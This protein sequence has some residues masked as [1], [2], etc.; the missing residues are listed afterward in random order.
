MK[1][2]RISNG[3][4]H[5]RGSLGGVWEVWRAYKLNN[6]Y[7]VPWSAV[8]LPHCFNGED[9]VDP[10]VLYYQGPGW[11]R[12]LLEVDNPYPNG[13]TLLHFEGAGQ[14]TEVYLYTEQVARHVG[15]YDEFKVDL[16]E[17][18]AEGKYKELF[19]NKV[20]VAVQC[21]NT[22]D[23]ETIPSDISDF[24][25]YGGIYRYLNLVYVPE[26]SFE[27]VHIATEVQSENNA[28]ITVRAKL[29]N[30]LKR[31]QSVRLSL[32]VR[33]PDGHA[34]HQQEWT[35]E[36]WQGWKDL[37]T[38]ELTDVKRWSPDHPELYSCEVVMHGATGE[39]AWETSHAERFGIRTFEFVKQGPFLLNGER[40]LLR[41]THRH[42]D[43]AG[44]AAAMTEDMI[45]SEMKLIKEMGA[46]FIR[47]GHYQQSRIV[48]ELC[49]ELGLLVWEEIP[50]CRG[51][52]GGEAYRQQC[53]DM[54]QAMIEQHYNHPSVIVWG[55]GNE[56]D[57]ESDFDTFDEEE[58]RRFMKELHDL[59]HELDDSRVT[60]IRRCEFCKDIIDVYSPSIWAGWY[61]GVYPEYEASSRAGFEGTDRFLHLEW[62]ADN[63]AGRHVEAPYTG[64]SEIKTGDGTDERDG[65]YFLQGGDPR[66]SSLG[67]W[68][69]TYFCDMIDWYLKSQTQ[70]D[71]LT[72]A[73]QWAFKDFSTPVRPDSPIPY[74]NMKGVVQRDLTPKEAY[75]VFQSYWSEKPMIRVYNH[76]EA[77]R[78]G[79]PGE[80]K[81][82]KVYSNCEQA[83][84]FLN[85]QSVGVRK[86]DA[87]DFPCAG[88][89]WEVE[90]AEGE[91][92]VRAVGIKN[93]AQVAD[94]IRFVYQTEEW[95]Q[96][97]SAVLSAN[98]L[99]DGLVK[100]EVRVYDRNGVY[101]PDANLF[102][103][104]GLAGDG[105]LL[106]NRGTVLGSRYL[107]LAG[108]RA[109]ILVDPQ[110]G[111]SVVS[112]AV[113]GIPTVFVEI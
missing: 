15:G 41:G 103:R 84:L 100:V 99:E 89:R 23:L 65:D 97:A 49:D 53:R 83:E 77:V 69:E 19:G 54:L 93:G 88:L 51:G 38:L 80:K 64:F 25:L 18:M 42:E 76:S 52:I 101:C 47:L 106:D 96:P 113:D 72:G 43:F 68:S 11:Y 90:L 92:E 5:Y 81:L 8:E 39:E 108:G 79:Q 59:S 3:W 10:D 12:T 36:A 45:R 31:S 104:F 1:T 6:H 55:L 56:N 2:K 37:A 34:V 74:L 87:Q 112:A 32:V 63:M 78:W 94:E 14:N 61:R 9:S 102:V 70:M 110:G 46:N 105:K 58:I 29:Y 17:Q 48:L 44:V 66:V 50:W 62:G 30:P 73:A 91:N 22:R 21:D 35:A 95:E 24:N 26:I 82:I 60:G 7:N 57:W 98:R 107:Q 28:E 20:P 27:Y 109:A 86:R 16:T 85:G 4:E 13:R 33:D 67:D 40:L 75:Y 111:R 71:W